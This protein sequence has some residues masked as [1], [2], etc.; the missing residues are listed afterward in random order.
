MNHAGWQSLQL[1]LSVWLIILS[2]FCVG[3]QDKGHACVGVEINICVA[4]LLEVGGG[5]EVFWFC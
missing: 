2:L 4:H 3:G 5:N 1:K